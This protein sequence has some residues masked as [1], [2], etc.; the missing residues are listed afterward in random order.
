[1]FVYIA[2]L[3]K[4]KSLENQERSSDG[5]IVSKEESFTCET[6]EGHIHPKMTA[7]EVNDFGKRYIVHN[8]PEN[9]YVILNGVR[10]RLDDCEKL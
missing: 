2:K 9:G 5:H 3:K 7:S 1:M 10:R 6:K 8:E 4:A